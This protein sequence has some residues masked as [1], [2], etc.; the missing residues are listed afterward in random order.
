MVKCI[1]YCTEVRFLHSTSVRRNPA[2]LN[3]GPD[4]AD[5]WPKPG[6][7]WKPDFRVCGVPR[8]PDIAGFTSLRDGVI[9]LTSVVHRRWWIRGVICGARQLFGLLLS[10]SANLLD[11]VMIT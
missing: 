8:A 11:S 1:C 5:P 4:T 3:P 7:P 10:S 6:G 2:P 9:Y